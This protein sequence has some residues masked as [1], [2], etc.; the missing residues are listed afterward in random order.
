VA[1]SGLEPYRWD[2]PKYWP[3][4]LDHATRSQLLAVGNALNLRFWTIDPDG[5]FHAM[6]GTFRDE[7]SCGIDVPVA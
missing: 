5:R 4:W 3:V 2:D 6:G 7:A 1:V